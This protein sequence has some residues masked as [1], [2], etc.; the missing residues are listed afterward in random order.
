MLAKIVT[1]DREYYSQVF[2]MF[3]PGFYQ[4]VVVFD[5][6]NSRFELINV[7]D[8]K[9]SLKRMVFIIDTDME[10]MINKK[11]IRLSWK[12]VYKECFGYEW[13]LDN[14]E[15]IKNIINGKVIDEKYILLAK[16]INKKIEI[17]EWK[18]VKTK[19]DANDLLHAALG[20]HDAELKEISY[21]L[22]ENYSD[23][24][25]VYVLFTGCWECDILLEFK[26]DVLVHFNIND[27]NSYEVLDSNILFN[28]GYV[29]WIDEYI[30]D[31]NNIKDSFNY[32]RGRSLKWKM[33]NK[34]IEE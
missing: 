15:L 22:K 20:F 21:K 23:P 18:Y 28:D 17:S 3:N 26:R 13:I 19:K 25:V 6:E 16:E 32:F 10:E 7:Y 8:I 31:I 2:A 33:I 27:L 5:D 29:Y 9:P 14:V 4:T 24:S 34:K 30:E 1:K 11:E 12:T